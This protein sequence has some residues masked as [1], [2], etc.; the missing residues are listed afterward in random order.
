ME[1]RDNASVKRPAP[2]RSRKRALNILETR[3]R[4]RRVV[5]YFALIVSFAFLVNALVGENGVLGRMKSSQDY[6]AFQARIARVRTENAAMADEA[7]RLKDDA[8][9]IE[10]VARER[11]NLIK[12]GE[13]LIILKDAKPAGGE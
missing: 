5:S 13:T 2:M 4:N 3:A 8:A 1:Q 12:P 9:T 6:D 7:R 11:L 10:S